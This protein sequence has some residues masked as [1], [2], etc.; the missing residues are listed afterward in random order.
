MGAMRSE[1]DVRRKNMLPVNAKLRMAISK[2]A[3]DTVTIR[4]QERLDD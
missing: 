1:R 3:G 2:H 4:L